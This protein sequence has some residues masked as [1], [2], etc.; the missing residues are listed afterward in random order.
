MKSRKKNEK[1]GTGAASRASLATAARR[2]NCAA[3]YSRLPPLFL[4]TDE[5]HRADPAAAILSLPRGAGVIFRHYGDP[6]RAQRAKDLA[7]ACR[8]RGLVFLVAGDAGLAAKVRASG[9]HLPE[10]WIGRAHALKRARRNWLVT[11]A[12]HGEA[13][14]CKAKESGADAA[15]LA[16]VF[17]TQSHPE[18]KPLGVLRFA[19][20]TRR[21]RL[22]VYALGGIDGKSAKRLWGSGAAGLAALRALAP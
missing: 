16:P 7:Q 17:A 13:A 20:L 22:P 12:A 18:R 9:V 11:V 15:F 5:S 4:V 2:L 1:S 19:T 6:A 10:H 8:M 3:G 21:T 14:L